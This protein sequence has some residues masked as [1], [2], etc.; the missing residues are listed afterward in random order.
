M[1]AMDTNNYCVVCGGP[2]EFGRAAKE[3]S[4]AGRKALVQVEGDWCTVCGEVLLTPQQAN[5]AQRRAAEVLRKEEGLL[6]PSEVREI[7]ARLGLTQAELETLLG[8]G[9][10]TVVRWERGTVFQSP[11]VDRLLRVLDASKEARQVLAPAPQAAAQKEPPKIVYMEDWRREQRVAFPVGGAT[12]E[13]ELPVI[14]M[15]AMQ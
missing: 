14:Q 11:P 8:V 7:R 10:K 5:D 3:V 12:G 9:P 13:I 1:T 15:E 2:V 6:S 4:I